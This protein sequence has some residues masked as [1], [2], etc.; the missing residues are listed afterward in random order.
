[1]RV[2]DLIEQLEAFRKEHGDD[3]EVLVTMDGNGPADIDTLTEG[4]NPEDFPEDWNMPD[5]WL[6]IT[7]Y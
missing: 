5:L 7:V 4:D 6:T 3:L 1:M 2:T